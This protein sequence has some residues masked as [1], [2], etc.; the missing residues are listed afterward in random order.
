MQKLISLFLL[1][2]LNA[3][4]LCAYQYNVSICAIFQNDG[5]YLKEWI[6]HHRTQG[7]EH[8]WLYNNN[9][10]DNFRDVLKPYIKKKIVE[11]IE[12]PGDAHNIEEWNNIQCRAYKDGVQRAKNVSKWC[13]FLDTDEFLFCPDGKSL[14]KALAGYEAFGGIGINWVMYGTSGVEKILP[15]EKL[16]NRLV[17]RVNL[18][19]PICLHIKTIAQPSR[20]IDCLNPHFFFYAPNQ[21]AAVTENKEP[22]HGPFTAYNSVSKFRINH[23]WSRDRYFFYNQKI[24]RREKWGGD[25]ANSI[26][27][28]N[29]FNAV[30][31]PI[32]VR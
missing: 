16:V 4:T 22:V 6:D 11:L 5:P 15:T 29:E 12:W 7:V 20:V 31:D 14:K 26:G 8:F 1:F 21:A 19:H 30:Y 3:H 13:A 28:E 17:Y 9:S 25:S 23:Y 2:L 24:P 10:N 32:L 18:D 27:M